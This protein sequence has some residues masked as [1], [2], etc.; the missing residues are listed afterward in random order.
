MFSI[1][2]NL[3]RLHFSDDGVGELG[4][5]RFTAEISRQSGSLLDDGE[6]GVLDLLGVAVQVHVT[7][8]HHRTQDQSSW[9]RL[10]L[11]IK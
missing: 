10:V 5:F 6:G 3:T 4:A 2:L 7:E 11:K 8:H 1:R 9:V